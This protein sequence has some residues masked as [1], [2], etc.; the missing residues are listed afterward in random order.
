M[1]T[2]EIVKKILSLK[3]D[4]TE[5]AVYEMIQEERTRAAGLLTEEAAAHLVAS[6]LGVQ[7]FI[8]KPFTSDIIE[9][10]LSSLIKTRK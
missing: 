6:K 3:P 7:D 8:E 9:G 4:L 1:A 2:Q 5:E 10:A